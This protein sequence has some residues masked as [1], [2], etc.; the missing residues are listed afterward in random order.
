M[1]QAGVAHCDLSGPNVLLPALGGGAGIALVDIEQLYA[2]E[3]RRPSTLTTNSDGYAQW[4]AA[5]EELWSAVGDRF[6]GA[7]LLAEMLGWYDEGV[8]EMAWGEH[9]FEQREMQQEGA[10]YETL[11][12]CP[13]FGEWVEALPARPGERAVVLASAAMSN[14]RRIHRYLVGKAA[15]E[16]E[17]DNPQGPGHGAGQPGLSFFLVWQN[18]LD[19]E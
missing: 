1:E 11:R 12:E 17:M 10:R 6:A 13:P 15:Q 2:P 18:R 8:R 16:A 3:L 14:L 7:V 4:A 9:Y 19:I 5:K